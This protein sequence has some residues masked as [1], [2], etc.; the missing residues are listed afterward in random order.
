MDD[1]KANSQ[2]KIL[3]FGQHKSNVWHDLSA[4]LRLVVRGFSACKKCHT[5]LVF[6]SSKPGALSLIKHSSS[7]RN[8]G[9][10]PDDTYFYKGHKWA[11]IY[12]FI[13]A[14]QVAY[15]LLTALGKCGFD[16]K[17]IA[18]NRSGD[19]LCGADTQNWISAIPWYLD[20][21]CLL[22]KTGWHEQKLQISY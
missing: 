7:C 13:I 15:L 17:I 3:N 10:A 12:V 14:R 9:A 2:W 22:R 11:T 4:T 5:I 8:T 19:E 18:G 21:F 16:L 1:I 6:D 20:K